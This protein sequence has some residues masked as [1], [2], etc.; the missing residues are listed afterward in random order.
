MI[1]FFWLL[2]SNI[3]DI[4][5]AFFYCL[6]SWMRK[7][8]PVSIVIDAS[9]PDTNSSNPPTSQWMRG[10]AN[11][12]MNKTWT[13]ACAQ[14]DSRWSHH[15]PHSSLPQFCPCLFQFP[16]PLENHS[17]MIAAIAILSRIEL[18][19]IWLS[20]GAWIFNELWTDCLLS[21]KIKYFRSTWQRLLCLDATAFEWFFT[22]GKET[23]LDPMFEGRSYHPSKSFFLQGNPKPSSSLDHSCC[24][25]LGPAFLR[26]RQARFHEGGF[27]AS[28]T[29]FPWFFDQE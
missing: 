23:C 7:N 13:G 4:F 1:L 3:V 19:I 22:C 8:P 20:Q 17:F 16:R 18:S 2:R 29:R 21:I 6:S 25:V 26:A 28:G 9:H 5:L 27:V 11:S 14:R 24:L 15:P 10:G 12:T